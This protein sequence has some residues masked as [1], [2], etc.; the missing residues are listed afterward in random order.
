MERSRLTITLRKDLLPQIDKV[1]DGEKIRNRSHAIEYLLLKSLRSRVKKAYILAAGE[2]VKMRPFT[3]EMPKTMLPVKGKPILQ[4]IVEQ[5]RDNDIREIVILVGH[6]DEKIKSYFGDGKKFG[7]HIDY[8]NC[9]QK[10]GTAKALQKAN[11]YLNDESFVML[12]GDTLAQIDLKDLLAFHEEEG[13]LATVALTSVPNPEG[14]GVVKLRG[15]KVMGFLEK[16]EK[17]PGLS[18]LISAGIFVIDPK[19]L[20]MIPNKKYSKLE[21]DVLPKLAR[22]GN[23]Y[24]YHFDG[25]WY[26]VGTPEIYERVLKEWKS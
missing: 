8:V 17:K 24:G 14:Y 9:K 4:H 10:V 19:I 21:D 26:D 12:Y 5:L 20:K 13:G 16:P 11:K 1:I 23:L 22:E 25:S 18:R 7:V 15:S 2:G 3:Y 6:M